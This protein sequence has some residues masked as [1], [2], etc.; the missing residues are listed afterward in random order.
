MDTH[1]N[2]SIITCFDRASTAESRANIHLLEATLL[3]PKIQ[4]AITVPMLN[5]IFFFYKFLLLFCPFRPTIYFVK[6][7]GS[8]AQNPR[9]VVNMTNMIRYIQKNLIRCTVRDKYG[10]E[11]ARIVE[12]SLAHLFDKHDCK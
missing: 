1:A 9:Y 10:V 11:T 3:H 8:D 6:I 12:V 7:P 2:G 5:A 4:V